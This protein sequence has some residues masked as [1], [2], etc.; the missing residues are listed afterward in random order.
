MKRSVL[1]IF[2]TICNINL[3]IFGF[4]NYEI[5]S[6]I[7]YFKEIPFENYSS[8]GVI[9]HVPRFLIVLP[10]YILADL[11]NTDP[12][13]IFTGYVLTLISATSLIWMRLQDIHIL[14]SRNKNFTWLFPFVLL[15]FING[16]FAFSLFGL[17]LMIFSIS[18]KKMN[19]SKLLVISLLIISLLFTSVSSGT[20]S[21]ALIYIALE[22]RRAFGAH[23]FK[24]K[25]ILTSII[26]LFSLIII[27][28]PLIYFFILFL[29]K[30]MNSYGGGL[31]GFIDMISHGL[32]LFFNPHP[33]LENC[34][35]NSNY[36]CKIARILI[37]SELMYVIFIMVFFF[38][39]IAIIVYLY[40]VAITSMAKRAIIASLIGGIFG[41]TAFMSLL[42][43]LPIFMHK[44]K[45]NY[46]FH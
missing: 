19:K 27:S 11:F 36:V 21:V 14:E 39:M 7:E 46:I 1:F 15:F 18:L 31:G 42:V 12:N 9:V 3:I 38:T 45:I 29:T 20:F 6:Q 13:Q 8:S 37:E 17:S 34:I 23:L 5:W 43:V 30:N 2:I 24:F 26:N 25:S 28:T 16:R 10:S 35:D 32:G 22:F 4:L 41:F 33:A 40:L 44:R